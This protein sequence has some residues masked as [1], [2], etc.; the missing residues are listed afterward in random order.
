MAR[1][2]VVA[3]PIGNLGDLTPRMREALQAADLIAAEDTRVTGKLL[4]HLGLTKPTVSCH[5]HNED[6]RAETIV[7]R[8]LREDL[9]VALTCD[10]G[11]PA[12]SDPGQALVD[13]AWAA[14]IEVVPVCGPSATVTA[15]SA[16]GF[17][18][19]EF[20]FYGFLPREKKALGEKL[21]L[22]RRAGIPVAVI[23]ESPHRI[24]K[25]MEAVCEVL[26]GAA[27][28]V[29]SDLSKYYERIYRGPC[30]DVLEQ[31]RS[32]PS[33]EKGEY[34]VVLD[35]SPLPAPEEETKGAEDAAAFMLRAV[36]DGATVDE[37]ADRARE[38]GYARNE[39]YRVR[40]RLGQMLDGDE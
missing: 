4:N 35:L 15:L 25:L 18:A 6:S 12:I 34:S 36:Y 1:L 37:A 5:R 21:A 38:K 26:P 17:D 28:C 7:V 8:M 11:T 33:V 24:V 27:A 3:T 31:L 32:N 9:T 40:L 29:C 20:A 39:I 13:A 19:R 14:G 10:A 22:I 2:Y 16:A 23:Y 30:E